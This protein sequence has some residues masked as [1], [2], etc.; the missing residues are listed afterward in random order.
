MSAKAYS[1]IGDVAVGLP[2]AFPVVAKRLPD[3]LE[4]LTEIKS[5]LEATTAGQEKPEAK[6]KHGA[7]LQL[8]EACRVQAGYLEV[9]IEAAEGDTVEG[10]LR[11]LLEAAVD[12]APAL[13][14]GDDD[15]RVKKLREALAEVSQL[16]PSLEKPTKDRGAVTL[17]NYDQGLQFYHG[18]EGDQNHNS[19]SG[20]MITGRGA[21]NNFGQGY[22]FECR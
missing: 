19:G 7:A 13:L 15:A 3:L 18:G 12:V 16:Q 21:T 2:D 9:L 20:V 6:E 11:K 8:A 5:G 14:G 4:A 10:V 17:N 22:P 1:C